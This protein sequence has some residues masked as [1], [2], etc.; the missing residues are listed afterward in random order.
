MNFD[1][2]NLFVFVLV[3]LASAYVLRG[4]WR[5][6]RTLRGDSSGEPSSCGS[7]GSCGAASRSQ[8]V[9]IDLRL[10]EKTNGGL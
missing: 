1:W 7:C 5:L 8:P 10:P 2:Q 6:G 3:S 4:V 9:V